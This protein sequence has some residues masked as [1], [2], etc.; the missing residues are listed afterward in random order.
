MLVSSHNLG[1]I[2]RIAAETV[3]MYLGEIVESGGTA[4]LF[5]GPRH[6]Y[7]AALLSAHPTIDPSAAAGADRAV[8]GDPGGGRSAVGVPVPHAVPD[9]AG[10]L[11]GRA[12]GV[13]AARRGAGGGAISRWMGRPRRRRRRGFRA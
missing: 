9:G 4:A 5:A 7:T 12:P 2:R 11:Q 10:P 1:V 8:G 13:A 3:V 6:P